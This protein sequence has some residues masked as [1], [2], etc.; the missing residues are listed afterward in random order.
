MKDAKAKKRFTLWLALICLLALVCAGMSFFTFRQFR[1]II[2][3]KQEA[4]LYELTQSI[5]RNIKSVLERCASELR[6]LVTQAEFREAALI[7]MASGEEDALLSRMR[8]NALTD[9]RLISNLLVIEDGRVSLCSTDGTVGDFSFPYGTEDGE[10]RL[11][12]GPEETLYMAF[13]YND[14]DT[15][16]QF[17]ALMDM[18]EF[19]YQIAGDEIN[20]DDWILLYDETCQILMRTHIGITHAD[21]IDATTSATWMEGGVEIL[22]EYQSQRT[23]GTR[24][25]EYRDHETGVSYKD[26]IAVYPTAANRNG[27]LA[28]GIATDCT[29]LIRQ[30][31]M[32]ALRLLLSAVL[33]I[34][35]VSVLIYTVL[36]S[37]RSNEQNLKDLESLK[38]R[39]DS[40]EKLLEKTQELARH[41]RLET[42]G[43]MTAGIA[44]EFNNMLTPIMG[45]SILCLEKLPE[46]EE[47]IGDNLV[48][49]YNAS[50]RAKELVSRL[51]ALTRKTASAAYTELDP[52]SLMD[53]ALA[54]AE[55]MRPQRVEIKRSYQGVGLCLRGD[56][57][58]LIQLFLNLIINAFYAMKDSGGELTASVAEQDEWLLLSIEDAG[59]G[60]DE[61]SLPH[62]FDPFFTTKGQANGSGLG[63]AIA[64]QAAEAHVGG[65]SVDTKPG[66]G[67]RFTVKLPVCRPGTQE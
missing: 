39:N 63:L 20:E 25:Y 34:A 27:V 16:L 24:T 49:I 22:L 12:I 62:I 60:I 46:A 31:D 67:S 29:N 7:W 13:I 36:L 5:D 37:T 28:V 59:T 53:K 61:Q 30:V 44:H 51:S 8:D 38:E 23:V 15:A 64:A 41:Q 58:Q 33:M 54:T 19:Y 11:C 21:Q 26:I 9:S 56:E 10:M 65:I 32:N 43:V 2:Y 17:A 57:T 47:E 48:E 50:L 66:Q 55:P 42:I 40:V 6:Y 3:E 4:N 52:E 35:C 14:A 1:S 45:Y 18:K